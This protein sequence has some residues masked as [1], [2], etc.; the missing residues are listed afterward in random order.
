MDGSI[1]YA[2]YVFVQGGMAALVLQCL[3]ARLRGHD[4]NLIVCL[5]MFV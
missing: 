1:K 5:R 4:N 3:D 2:A